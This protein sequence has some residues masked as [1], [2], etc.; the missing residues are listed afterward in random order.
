[1]AGLSGILLIITLVLISGLVAYV[2]DIVGRRMGRRRLSLFGLRPRHT[3]IVI[4]VISGMLITIM[5]LA[6][7][8][9]ASRDVREGLLRVVEMR[10]RQA[11]LN[12]QIAK[13][14]KSMVKLERTRDEAER[15]LEQRRRERDQAREEL[16]AAVADLATTKKELAAAET[17]LK[18]TEMAV[19]RTEAA[20][21][22]LAAASVNAAHEKNQLQQDVE[23]LRVQLAGG[24]AMERATPVLFGAGQPLDWRLIDGNRPASAI[25]QDLDSFVAKLDAQVKRI[26]AKPLPGEKLTVIIRKPVLQRPAGRT[27]SQNVEW[28]LQDQVLDALADGIHETSGGVIVRAFSVFNTHAGEPVRTDFELF[29]NRL[30]FHRGDVLAQERLDGGEPEPA[31]M[32]ALLRLLREQVNAKARSNNIMPKAAA[33]D[34]DV[35]GATQETVGEMTIEELFATVDRLRAIGGPARVSAVASSDTW[36]IGPLKVDLVV[37][38]A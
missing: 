7:A 27:G 25:R 30:I 28:F 29:R 38:P 12:A 33:A 14:D 35:I 34:S 18:L 24:I 32:G 36:T 11:D 8:M 22:R 5:T 17:R 10:Q 15:E 26:G 4:S 31:L 1:M 21:R 19:K 6:V 37:T 2:G 13:L 3:A 23:N 20:A 16:K 9:T